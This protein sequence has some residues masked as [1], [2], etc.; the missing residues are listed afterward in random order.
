MMPKG[1]ERKIVP[2]QRLEPDGVRIPMMP[3][4]VERN[5]S[6]SRT[7]TG[8][9]VRIPMMPK[10][11]ERRGCRGAQRLSASVNKPRLRPSKH[12]PGIP[13]LPL[14]KLRYAEAA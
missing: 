2:F 9:K 4:G 6:I 1:V 12:G 10:G 13:A 11:V 3:K 7:F 8:S 14:C 5:R